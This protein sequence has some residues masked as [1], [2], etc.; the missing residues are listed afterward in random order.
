MPEEEKVPDEL[1]AFFD[2]EEKYYYIDRLEELKDKIDTILR[3]ASSKEIL[4]EDSKN[5]FISLNKITDDF[6]KV[7]YNLSLDSVRSFYYFFLDVLR[8]AL[9]GGT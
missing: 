2:I 6:L 1:S 7:A 5:V 3:V 4:P 9:K 8:H